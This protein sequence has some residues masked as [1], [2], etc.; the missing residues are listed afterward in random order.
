MKRLVHSGQ[1]ALPGDI[2]TGNT[3]HE[4]GRDSVDDDFTSLAAWAKSAQAIASEVLGCSQ[5]SFIGATALWKNLVE[6]NSLDTA[7]ELQRD[8]L[9]GGYE[10]FVA[11][12]ARLGELYAD[13]ATRTCKLFDGT[14]SRQ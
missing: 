2:T 11:R 6:A 4:S 14:L 13:L 8:Y 3:M 1:P 5:H 9:K 7:L 12:A 10:D